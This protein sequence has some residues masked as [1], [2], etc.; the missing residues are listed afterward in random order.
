VTPGATHGFPHLS[1]ISDFSEAIAAVN[2]PV[3]ARLKRDFSTFTALGAGCREHLA[4][5]SVTAVSEALRLSGLSAFRTAFRLVGVAFR[6]KEFLVFGAKDKRGTAIGALKGLILKT[7][8]MT[9]SL[10]Y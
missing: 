10:Y 5:S 9:S 6:L 2:R 7:H 4:W 8:W 1:V 3:T